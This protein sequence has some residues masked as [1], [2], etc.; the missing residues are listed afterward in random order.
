MLRFVSSFGVNKI[1]QFINPNKRRKDRVANFY[2]HL[3]ILSIV[4]DFESSLRLR[5][6]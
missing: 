6:S 5:D 4:L 3:A 2:N 1:T